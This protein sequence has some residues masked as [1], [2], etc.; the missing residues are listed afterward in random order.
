[1]KRTTLYRFTFYLMG[2]IILALGITLNT[3]VG[4]GVSAII[5][6]SYSISTI[7]HGNFGNITLILYSIFVVLEMVLHT[8]QFLKTR[9]VRSKM[10]RMEVKEHGNEKREI[11]SLILVKDALQ[12]P[13]SLLF[14][15]F[16]NL[17][18]AAIPAYDSPGAGI[19]YSGFAGR[20]L[21]LILAIIFNGMGTAMSLNMRLIP[22]PADGIVQ[23]IAD[24]TGKGVGFTK[25]C[26]D[27][28]NISITIIVGILFAGRLIGIG[29]GTVLAVIGVGRVIAVFNHFFMKKMRILAG[30]EETK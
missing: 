16:L 4:L 5:S 27:L 25:N 29:I 2:L 6:V 22:D 15:R 23:A 20:I 12:F 18:A 8:V 26:F 24:C 13:L 7:T 17:F 11:L 14:T 30:M 21:V 10:K 3:K 1:M 28:F 19:F 9:N